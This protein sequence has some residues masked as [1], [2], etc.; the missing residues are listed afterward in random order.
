MV[1]EKVNDPRRDLV[2]PVILNLNFK[3]LSGQAQ[4]NILT[5]EKLRGRE[6]HGKGQSW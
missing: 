6:I 1:C 4:R 2:Q 3:N 5:V